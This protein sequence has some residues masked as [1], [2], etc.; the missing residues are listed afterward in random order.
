MVRTTRV[1]GRV[2]DEFFL[3]AAIRGG[4]IRRKTL[5]TPRHNLMKKYAN[6][7]PG[8]WGA[9]IGAAAVGHQAALQ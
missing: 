6:L 7:K 2:A 1:T 5:L 8:I 9:V 4:K 3:R